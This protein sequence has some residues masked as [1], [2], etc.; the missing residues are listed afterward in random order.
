[1]NACQLAAPSPCLTWHHQGLLQL[2]LHQSNL[3]QSNRHRVGRHRACRRHANRHRV[4]RLHRGMHLAGLHPLKTQLVSHPL[5]LLR[6]NMHF[7]GLRLT[8]LLLQ[9][10]LLP[11]LRKLSP[12]GL[13][14][15]CLGL[16]RPSQHQSCRSGPYLHEL[17]QRQ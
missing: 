17:G 8:G 5:N 13:G 3:H 6:A 11:G 15:R 16:L 14:W 7:P 4:G 2:A 9:D 12:S 1:M 10:S